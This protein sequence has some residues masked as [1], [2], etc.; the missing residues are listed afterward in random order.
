[1]ATITDYTF[2]GMSRIGDDE[3]SQTTRN[4]Q[5]VT[6]ANHHLKNY[7]LSDLTLPN[8]IE[9]A[10]MQPGIN[11]SGPMHINATGS[12]IDQ[13]SKMLIGGIQTR[14]GCKLTLHQ[15]PYASVPYLGRGVVLPDIETDITRG[16]VV[17]SRKSVTKLPEKNIVKRS[18]TPLV[19]KLKDQIND[20]RFLVESI[21]HPNWVR[22]GIPTRDLMRDV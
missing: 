8:A 22:G 7:A 4:L 19:P 16:Q 9:F 11:Y 17:S 5:N 14:P 6:S 10:T 15:R 2:Y 20:P 3:C 12:N 18:K 13:S 1:M 21:A